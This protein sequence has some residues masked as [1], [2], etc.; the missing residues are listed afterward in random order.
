MTLPPI[1]DVLEAHGLWADKRFGQNFLTDLNI[2]RRIASFGE[3]LEGKCVVEIGPGPGG[4][5]RAILERNP[6]ELIAIEMDPRCL[7]IL[8]EI[9]ALHPNLTI[10]AGDAL[11]V[12]LARLSAERGEK[13]TVIANLPYNVST[14]LLTQ[15]LQTPDVFHCLVLMF[16]KE[17]A[18]RLV[19]TPRTGAYG[20]LSILTQWMMEARLCFDLPPTVF[21]PPP[22]V[23]STVVKL[24]PKGTVPPLKD[25]HA[26]ER[27]TAAAF[28]Q[29][30]KMVRTSLKSL[31]V[32]VP[33]LLDAANIPET[34]RAEE[35]ALPDFLRLLATYQALQ[36]SD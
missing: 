11:D 32:D 16:Q 21:T 4:L 1:R 25:I 2:T 15:W 24:T 36:E 6:K 8:E 7:G 9:K 5:T 27:L 23:T 33:T 26:L 18:Q 14:K 20:R 10:L 13:L 30:R 34:C 19:A 3:P 35:L 28:G 29:R 12:S 31:G 22:K 17:V